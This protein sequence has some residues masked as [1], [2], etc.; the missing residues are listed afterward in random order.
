[1]KTFLT[2]FILFVFSMVNF[3]IFGQNKS[4]SIFKDATLILDQKTNSPKDIRFKEGNY[5]SLNSFFDEYRKAFNLSNQNEFRSFR[6]LT[7]KLGQTHLR[8]KQYYKGI[9]LAEVQ[10]ILH[11]K[12]GMVFH[13]NGKLIHGLDLDVTPSLSE[14]DA[15]QYAL[16]D[17]NAE[18]YMWESKKN[19][20]YLKREQNDPEATMYPK[21][22]LMLS[23]K[24][25]D[26]QKE[27]FHLVYRFD[28]SSEKPMDRV[29]IDVDAKTGEIINKISRIRTG[30]VQG[31]GTS[32]YNGT[33]SLTVA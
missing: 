10:F 19:E 9:E 23:A 28:I 21:G 11:E 2:I 15:L 32:F 33:V 5:I 17:I 7:D 4:S 6:V 12:N 27:N 30:D 29:Y 20:A 25:F 24:N 8:Y 1:M 3:Q 26:L 31:Q 22:V 13:A 18:A 16:S 14:A